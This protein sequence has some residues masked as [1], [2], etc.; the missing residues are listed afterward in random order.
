MIRYQ[1][2][3]EMNTL[4]VIK[5]ENR[6]FYIPFN[7]YIT[8]EGIYRQVKSGVDVTVTCG[9]TRNDITSEVLKKCV[10]FKSTLSTEDLYG[11]L[12]K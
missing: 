3:L 10:E 2:K 11:L 6:K 12:R 7:G 4:N 5:Y 1:E 9:V 8:L